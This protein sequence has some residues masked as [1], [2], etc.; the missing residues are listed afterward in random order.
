MKPKHPKTSKAIEPGLRSFDGLVRELRSFVTESRR[1]IIRSV[2]FA[3]VRTCWGEGRYI[4]EFEQEGVDRAKCG[5]KLLPKL[6]EDL[7]ADFREQRLIED[8]LGTARKT[9]SRAKSLTRKSRR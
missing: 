1:Q 9:P 5:A 8:K 2:D 4:V 3:Q 7:T 6:A